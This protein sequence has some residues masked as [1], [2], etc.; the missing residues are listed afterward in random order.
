M[1]QPLRRRTLAP[2]FVS[3]SASVADR[4]YQMGEREVICWPAEVAVL[5]D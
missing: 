5:L 4:V 2:I 1:T 3:F